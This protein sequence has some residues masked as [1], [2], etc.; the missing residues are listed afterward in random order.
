[1]FN[2]LKTYRNTC[3]HTQTHTFTPTHTQYHPKQIPPPNNP[4]QTP[5]PKKK[6]KHTTKT[7]LHIINIISYLFKAQTTIKPICSLHFLANS[8]TTI[9][10]KQFIGFFVYK[11]WHH[12]SGRVWTKHHQLLTAN[13]T[14]VWVEQHR[15][16]T[17]ISTLLLSIIPTGL[18]TASQIAQF[19]HSN[20]H[21][22][23]VH[24]TYWAV[25]CK[26]NSTV[27]SQ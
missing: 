6:K 13:Y 27:L 17:V 5:P 14:W 23:T 3:T 10:R 24:N 22:V 9:E 19:C 21:T 20:I 15:F 7:T 26:S 4:I 25:Y 18:S 12:N 2:I 11:R 8:K 1:M 16:V